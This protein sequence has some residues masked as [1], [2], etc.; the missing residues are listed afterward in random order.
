MSV[1][2]RLKSLERRVSRLEGRGKVVEPEAPERV[3]V[4]APPR[5]YDLRDEQDFDYPHGKRKVRVRGGKVAHRRPE[6]V[7]GIVLHQTAVAFGVSPRQVEASH[8]DE[9]LALARRGLDVA[10]HAIAFRRGLYVA[11][12]PLTTWVNHGN[13]YNGSTLGLEVD[14]RY[15]GLESQPGRTTWGGDPTTLTEQTIETARAALRW[16]VDTGRAEGMPIEWI[17]AHRQ[18]SANRRSDPGEGLWREVVLN[19]AVPELGLKTKPGEYVGDGRPVPREWD[20]R[21]SV[22]Y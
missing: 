2:A 10:C 4:G 18:S 9:R 6:D 20:P 16:L 11:T 21:G 13:A 5:F 1:E 19:F 17:Y 8:G 15:P 14:G 12:H 3:E 22:S 7:T